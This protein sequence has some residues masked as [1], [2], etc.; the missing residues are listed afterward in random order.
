M[1]SL[2]LPHALRDQ[3]GRRFRTPVCRPADRSR[4]ALVGWS[5]RRRVPRSPATSLT[6]DAAARPSARSTRLSTARILAPG[7]CP[8]RD[9][10][11][12]IVSSG[13]SYL[14]FPAATGA[15]RTIFNRSR[16][17]CSSTWPAKCTPSQASVCGSRAALPMLPPR[18][19]KYVNIDHSY[20][21]RYWSIGNEPNL[22]PNYSLDSVC[23]R[24]AADLPRRCWLSIRRSSSSAPTSASTRPPNCAT[25]GP[26]S[27]TGLT[28]FLKA[29]GDLVG[30]VSIHRYPFPAGHE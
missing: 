29:N 2:L 11:P 21:V 8:A 20:G 4:S 19:C 22:Y 7:V 16:S 3:A 30:I 6:V 25:I 23:Q 12:A 10:M 14:R 9:I 26:T 28:T 13:I 27:A 1:K 17:I 24:L 5:P 15:T 18:W